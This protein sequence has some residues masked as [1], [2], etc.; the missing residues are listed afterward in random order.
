[1]I[2]WIKSHYVLGDTGFQPASVG[3]NDG[4]IVEVKEYKEGKDY[5]NSLIVPGFIDLHTH[6]G[7]GYDV[8]EANTDGMLIWLNELP[9]E[10]TT[11]LLISPYTSSL[12]SMKESVERIARLDHNK[13]IPDVLGIYLEGPFV[14]K[15]Q[16]GA[17]PEAYVKKPSIKDFQYIAG[18]DQNQI[19]ICAMACEEDEHY[20]LMNYLSENEII[21]SAGHTNMSFD[22]A[23]S[24][25][26]HGMKSFTHVFNAMRG[27]HHR[28]VGTAGAAML[29]DDCYAEIIMD[30]KHV[31]FEAIKLLYKTKR[32]KLMFITDSLNIKGCKE[33]IYDLDG[34]KIEMK[35]GCAYLAGSNQLAGSTMTML[36]SVQNAVFMAD[37]PIIEAIQMA[38][39]NP[40]KLL[41]LQD[42]KGKIK[43]GFDCDLCVLEPS[44][45]L[46]QTYCRGKE[47]IIN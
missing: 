47:C 18:S 11:S 27:I 2:T 12:T 34:I 19:K 22:Q 13:I 21:I 44:L 5:G 36:K 6:G 10:G 3:I 43:E 29:F 45:Q 8:M 28:D 14:S 32:E 24:A 9:K 26:N 35:K 16:L 17:M 38:S 41:E 15:Q 33:G 40:A 46:I 30:G 1:M 4:R 25:K 7:Y 20:Q 31:S 39:Q 23:I 37:I 42:R